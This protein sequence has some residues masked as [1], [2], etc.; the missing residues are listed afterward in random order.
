[1]P[2]DHRKAVL[3]LIQIHTM[4]IGHSMAALYEPETLILEA[5]RI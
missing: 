1:M 5:V 4:S 3:L 2:S